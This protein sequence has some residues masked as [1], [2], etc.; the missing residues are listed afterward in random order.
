MIDET[1]K[2]LVPKI[3]LRTTSSYLAFGCK[4]ISWKK[5]QRIL[6]EESC[7]PVR[8]GCCEGTHS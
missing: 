5:E 6:K 3:V 4:V 2:R 8:Q 1:Y 7:R